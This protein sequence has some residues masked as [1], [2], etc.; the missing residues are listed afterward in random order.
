L[1][2]GTQIW[3]ITHNGVD[4]HPVHFHLFSVQLVNRVGWDGAVYPPEPNE[5][6]WKEVVRMNPLSDVIVALRPKT[7]TLP[8]KL[9]NSKHLADSTQPNG[10]T[11]NQPNLSPLGGRS[12][13]VNRVLNYGWEYVW[14]CHILGHEEN[15]FMRSIAVAVPPEDPSA[16]TVT[17]DPA[18]NFKGNTLNWADNSMVSNWAMITRATDAGFTQNVT[19]FPVAYADCTLQAGCA[20]SYKDTSAKLNTTYFYR[21]ASNSTVGAGDANAKLPATLNK[22]NILP[23]DNAG[24]VGAGFLGYDNVTASSNGFAS[25]SVTYNPVASWSNVS[26]VT[27]TTANFGDLAVGATA[28]QTL[29]LYNTGSGVLSISSI[30]TSGAPY[31]V[32]GGTCSSATPV[33]PA[34]SCTVIVSF[35]PTAAGLAT[36]TLTINDNSGNVASAQTATLTGNGISAPLTLSSNALTFNV[37]NPTASTTSTTASTP[38]TQTVTVTNASAAPVAVTPVL[39]GTGF[40]AA[41]GSTCSA[42]TPVAAGGTC[43]YNIAY[44][45]STTNS[46]LNALG[47]LGNTGKVT[48]T[49]GAYS[50]VVN[51]T[52]NAAPKA[53]TNLARSAVAANSLTLKW[54]APA[55]TVASY[56]V[57]QATTAAGP[58]TPA[59]GTITGTSMAV[60]GLVG[61]TTYYFRVAANN[62][63][64][65]GA[66]TTTVN[67]TTP[68]A[69][70]TAISA[71]SGLAAP[72]D[73]I[74]TAGLN[75]TAN[76]A[77][78]TYQVRYA[79][80]AAMTSGL[81]TVNNA[82]SGQQI[83]VGGVKRIV[84]MQVRITNGTWS[85]VSAL[86]AQAQ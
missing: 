59:T 12:T 14:H 33:N 42:L 85:P 70:P 15:D 11:A 41:A 51:L 4:T 81:V 36:G 10:S 3:K 39:T 65:Q 25:N 72:A 78:T 74:I 82:V 7:L 31:T 6:G 57:M 27:A 66:F 63:A 23:T 55:N 34:A 75:W 46:N 67:A 37:Y 1:S 71:V 50:T 24:T 32:T 22:A 26:V 77:G 20:R 47:K 18:A 21:V 73:A 45:A 61:N 13:I 52:G 56:S 60:T 28:P 84:Y 80:N 69:L 58:W 86:A 29:T 76:N 8:F 43:T 48:F 5:V 19:T 30:T 40:T 68:R 83:N 64:G 62:A 79:N 17:A 35:A 53:P 44:I 54:T 49:S 16:L 2:D 9:G 38:A